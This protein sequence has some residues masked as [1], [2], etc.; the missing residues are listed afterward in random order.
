VRVLDKC[1]PLLI[2]L[3]E[4]G[5]TIKTHFKPTEVLKNSKLRAASL[6]QDYPDFADII[7]MRKELASLVVKHFLIDK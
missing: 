1:M 4:G 2:Q 7:E 3:V 5:K 6:Y